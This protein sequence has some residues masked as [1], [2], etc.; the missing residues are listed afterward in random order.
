MNWL[1]SLLYGLISGITE[2]L[3]ISSFAHHQLYFKMLDMNGIDP[4][5]SLLV[6]IALIA[7]VLTACRSTLEQYYRAKVTYRKDLSKIRSSNIQLEYRF[8]KNAILPMLLGYFVLDRFLP[9]KVNLV[10]IAV[11]SFINFLILMFQTRMMQG[12]KDER[13]MSVMDS[14]TI[15]LAGA[16]SAIPGI[17]RTCIM[18]TVATHRGVDKEKAISWS[19]LL[20]VPILVMLSLI[21]VVQWIA[22][23]GA[24]P[25]S[26]NILGYILSTVGAYISG[27]LGVIFIK[28][29]A[30]NKDIS[31][32]AFYSLGIT[33]FALFLYLTV[34]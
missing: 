33:I 5:Q 19:I 18:L 10:W 12:N 11:I 32:F 24:V 23:S 34:V 1:E 9:N 14:F 30:F 6:H 22:S 29:Y 16:L 21:D 4:I 17:S 25:V 2:F 27:Y 20:S 31:D 8:L 15:G 3:P 13:T 28:S 7:A 26:G